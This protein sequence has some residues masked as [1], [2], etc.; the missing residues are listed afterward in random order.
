MARLQQ[1][2]KQLDIENRAQVV[3][4]L[5]LIWKTSP[6]LL[7]A[8]RQVSKNVWI[9]EDVA[10][11]WTIPFQG[12]FDNGEQRSNLRFT[13]ASGAVRAF[14]RKIGLPDRRRVGV[15]TGDLLSAMTY[16]Q[17]LKDVA[18]NDANNW[19]MSLSRA[20]DVDIVLYRID[21][22]GDVCWP[23]LRRIPEE[24]K[25]NRRAIAIGFRT[26]FTL[27]ICTWVNEAGPCATCK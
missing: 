16:L 19:W 4:P 20:N 7:I 24:C 25:V 14:N 6:T 12:K 13:V 1:R 22:H 18:D 21:E 9:Q 17:R 8:E 5:I 27:G 26:E 15:S 11:Q 10:L 3:V 2:L 23:W